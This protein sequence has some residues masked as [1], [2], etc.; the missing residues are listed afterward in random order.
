MAFYA[1]HAVSNWKLELHFCN[2][3]DGV[4]IRTIVHVSSFESVT[5]MTIKS[6]FPLKTTFTQPSFR[7]PKLKEEPTHREPTE[8]KSEHKKESKSKSSRKKGY[9]R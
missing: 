8:R 2:L 3:P 6:W 1:F 4:F 9:A 7:C 5:E